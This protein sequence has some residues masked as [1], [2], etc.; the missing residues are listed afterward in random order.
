MI[1]R[2]LPH[3]C[4]HVA[5]QTNIR[6]MVIRHP[7]FNLLPC[8]VRLLSMLLLCMS[9]RVA[10]AQ[11]KSPVISV[12]QMHGT[13]GKI[14][15][16]RSG[17]PS[18]T[19]DTLEAA[20]KKAKAMNPCA[21]V[22][23][24]EGPGGLVSEMRK[25]VDVLY[26]A[27][28]VDGMRV[29]ALVR[30]AYSAWAV[31]ALACKEI[32]VIP[33][34]KIGAA[35]VIQ[36]NGQG[37]FVE[38]PEEQG[39]VAQ[40]FIAPWK[41]LCRQVDDLTG[42]CQC[43]RDAMMIQDKELWGNLNSGFA[44]AAGNG[45]GWKCLDN[46][47][48]VC[49]LTAD[50]MLT[51]GLAT[52]RIQDPVKGLDELPIALKCPPGSLVKKVTGPAVAAAPPAGKKPAEEAFRKA[53]EK[54]REAHALAGKISF[55]SQLVTRTKWISEQ[56]AVGYQQRK[57]TQQERETPAEVRDRVDGVL[58]QVKGKI[59]FATSVASDPEFVNAIEEIKRLLAEAQR[60]LKAEATEAVLDRVRDA[61]AIM[62]RF[63]DQY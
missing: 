50:E 17:D 60:H 6:G 56:G 9:A 31:I 27:Q 29:V 5:K 41:A 61:R 63:A 25:M 35:V 36:S 21:I 33:T 16:N 14:P 32:I 13:V 1:D 38:A 26:K 54:L 59:P 55:S 43:I 11:D 10:L 28:A 39:A 20:L 48:T 30:N 24:I 7:L 40:K 3:A 44:D 51:Y 53:A 23:D 18:F 15:G 8:S 19:A 12:I 34:S 49:C 45:P 46:K 22:L 52:E 57:V 62:K 42:R 37:G 47:V 58:K 4:A 2:L